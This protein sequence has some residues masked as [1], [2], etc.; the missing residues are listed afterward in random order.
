MEENILERLGALEV[1]AAMGMGLL[2]EIAAAQRQI[3]AAVGGNSQQIATIAEEYA[4]KMNVVRG[5]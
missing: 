2:Q 1:R 5:G 3:L 4:R